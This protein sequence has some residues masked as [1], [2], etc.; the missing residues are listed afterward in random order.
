MIFFG[1]RG[2]TVSGQIVEGIDCPSCESKQFVTFGVIKYFHLYWIPTFPTSRTVGIEC[3]HCRRTLIDK[4][5]PAK[6]SGEIK[7]TVFKKKNV[8]PLFSGLIII[9]CLVLFGIYSVQKD[10]LQEAAYIEQPLADDFYIVNY[11]KIFPDAD[12]KYKYGLMRIKEVNSGRVEFQVSKIAYNKVSG[13]RTDIRNRKASSDDY[14]DIEPY[15]M[16]AENLPEMRESGA[17]YSIE[18]E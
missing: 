11:A 10:K 15:Y 8:L 2:K 13:V 3:T 5:L 7:A 6:L 12:E 4:D 14:Y 9:A 18:R 17:I 1:S 16:A